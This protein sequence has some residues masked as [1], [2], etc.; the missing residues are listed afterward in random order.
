MLSSEIMLQ[1]DCSHLQIL[2]RD[3]FPNLHQH[4]FRHG[5][6]GYIFQNASTDLLNMIG[7]P[8]RGP[9]T[10]PSSHWLHRKIHP[11]I[12]DSLIN[13]VYTPHPK[14]SSTKAGSAW[15]PTSVSPGLVL[16]WAWESFPAKCARGTVCLLWGSWDS[17]S[18][19]KHFIIQVH[20]IIT[21]LSAYQSTA[22]LTA[23]S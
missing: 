5:F 11:F 12:C 9:C 4:V 14:L 15:F 13:H 3:L 16:N 19:F 6:K 21:E 7:H 1:G 8:I 20:N 23:S 10:F 17:K 22:N 2:P 18:P